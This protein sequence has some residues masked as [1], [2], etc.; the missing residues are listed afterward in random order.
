ME[1]NQ[2]VKILD[3]LN[4]KVSFIL[5][6]VSNVKENL[7][8]K[9]L[10]QVE[11]EEELLR[12]QVENEEELLSSSSSNMIDEVD[13]IL[14]EILAMKLMNNVYLQLGLF[15]K[16]TDENFEEIANN[17]VLDEEDIALLIEKK[18]DVIAFLHNSEHMD[19]LLKLI[20]ELTNDE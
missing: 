18:D 11:N 4:Q 14:I 2:I 1:T 8:A 10:E 5:S 7:T 15:D 16:A 17:S 19:M 13:K 6:E 20:E 9:E 12:E 3:S